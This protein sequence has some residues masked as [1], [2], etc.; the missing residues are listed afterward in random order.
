MKIYKYCLII[1]SVLVLFSCEK[2]TEGLSLSTY[3]VAFDMKGD[4]PLLVPV[5]TAFTDPGVIA[6]E[7]GKDV[8]STIKTESNVNPD[9]MGKYSIVYSGVNTNGLKSRAIRD[10]FVCNPSVTSD[11]SGNY[12]VAAGSNRL[13][14]ASGAE[15]PYSGYPITI[16]RV[17]P[18]FFSVSDFFGGYYDK[19]AAYGARYAMTGYIALNE[20]NTINLVTSSVA[21]W[22]DSLDELNDGIYNP[23]T[24]IIS[25]GAVY[26]GAYSFNVILTK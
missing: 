12:T 25:W 4:N 11:I 22:G 23:E 7:Q 2:E 1:F 21:G 18:G 8:T 13:A 16:T 20:D 19:R 6:T 5:G 24:G 15:I 10:V 9:V 14:F 3:Y 17:A 26:A